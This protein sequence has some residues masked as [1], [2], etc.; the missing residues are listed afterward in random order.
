MYNS[1]K[2]YLEKILS[3]LNIETL[4]KFLKKM[5]FIVWCLWFFYKRTFNM[6][7]LCFLLI[8]EALIVK[9]VI[10][11]CKLSLLNKLVHYVLALSIVASIL[12]AA[13]NFPSYTPGKALKIVTNDFTSRTGNK[14]TTT[15]VFK[16]KNYMPSFFQ[17]RY[18]YRIVIYSGDKESVYFFESNTGDY[19]VIQ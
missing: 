13:L 3:Y 2:T 1:I 10:K 18:D 14:V 19:Y 8:I 12:I 16:Y 15:D 6:L 17:I 7:P 5:L 11:R 9:L 4:L